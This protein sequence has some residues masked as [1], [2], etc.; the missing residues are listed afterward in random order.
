M[1]TCPR[2]WGLHWPRAGSRPGRSPTVAAPAR[3]ARGR[4]APFPH[5][6]SAVR[7][8][9]TEG[10]GE[11][12]AA[13]QVACTPCSST[14]E[15]C[16]RCGVVLYRAVRAEETAHGGAGGLVGVGG[17]A[18]LMCLVVEFGVSPLLL[19]PA[20]CTYTLLVGKGAAWRLDHWGPGA[21]SVA[22]PG[23]W[24][25]KLMGGGHAGGSGRT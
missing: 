4:G 14:Q 9:A 13:G 15:A 6:L 24:G 7:E 23:L 17:P 25:W 12:A 21:T 10:A 19:D 22:P 2:S 20:K 18:T 16:V 1:L 3:V 5:L 8:A 11:T